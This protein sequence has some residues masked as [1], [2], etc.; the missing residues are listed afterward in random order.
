MTRCVLERSAALLTRDRPTQAL[1]KDADGGVTLSQ[2]TI[3]S[4]QDDVQLTDVLPSPWLLLTALGL[5]SSASAGRPPDEA[6]SHVVYPDV[7]MDAAH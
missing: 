3:L 7:A 6:V 5:G 2:Q 1:A 4:S